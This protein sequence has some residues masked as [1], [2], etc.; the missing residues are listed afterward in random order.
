[1]RAKVKPTQDPEQLSEN[2]EKRVEEVKVEDGTLSVEISEEKLDVLER[3][4]GVEYFTAGGQE[5][6]GLK[7]RPVQERAYA[8][9]ESRRDLAEAVAA[10]IQ[11][12]DLVV[13]NTERDWDLKAL[14]KF[15]PDLKHLKQ[16]EPI[17]I[18]D[19]D[20]TLQKEDKSREYVGPD[21]SNEEVDV[22]YSFA[23]AGVEKGS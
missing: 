14:R 2:L 5:T 19:I 12:Y 20:S 16:D 3:T 4:P 22:I 1:M 18:L 9:V 7:G 6:E 15:N 17:D 11:G 13:L 23:F 10:T 8:R 21:L